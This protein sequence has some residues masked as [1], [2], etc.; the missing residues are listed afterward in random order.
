MASR[1]PLPPQDAPLQASPKV[2]LT[3][4]FHCECCRRLKAEK[5]ELR[6]K[7]RHARSIMENLF[8]LNEAD[9]EVQRQLNNIVM[10][11]TC[12]RG[13]HL[14]KGVHGAPCDT[15]GCQGVLVPI[16]LLSDYE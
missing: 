9:E 3:A 5:K 8:R 13:N 11:R 14:G 16:R 10:I 1:S 2:D 6:K 7:R 12:N 15:L 4:R